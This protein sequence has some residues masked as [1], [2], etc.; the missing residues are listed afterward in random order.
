MAKA[1]ETREVVTRTLIEA[2]ATK[3]IILRDDPESADKIT[4]DLYQ[5]LE[6]MF[7]IKRQEV[8]NILVDKFKFIHA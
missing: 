8:D 1:Q 2:I 3:K 4:N 6:N 7:G 5:A